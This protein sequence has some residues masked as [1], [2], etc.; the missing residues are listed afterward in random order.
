MIDVMEEQDGEGSRK[1]VAVSES[2]NDV[3]VFGQN[4]VQAERASNQSIDSCGFPGSY[5]VPTVK[6]AR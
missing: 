5:S 4:S 6:K 3:A 2:D 1:G